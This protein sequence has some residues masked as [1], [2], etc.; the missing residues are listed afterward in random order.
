MARPT[1]AV[2]ATRRREFRQHV[3]V[4]DAQ[5]LPRKGTPARHA[6]ERNRYG[7]RWAVHALNGAALVLPVAESHPVKGPGSFRNGGHDAPPR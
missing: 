1:A 3:P 5:G 7:L 6:V 2:G 4:R